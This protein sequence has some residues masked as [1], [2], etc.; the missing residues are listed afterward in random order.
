L[1][2]YADFAKCRS[3]RSMHD[4]KIVADVRFESTPPP[5]FRGAAKRRARASEWQRRC[6]APAM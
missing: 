6:G 4:R 3:K 5:S 2:T 1:Q